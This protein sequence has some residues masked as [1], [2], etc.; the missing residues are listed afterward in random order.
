[1]YN[2]LPKPLTPEIF[3][4]MD[5][6]QILYLEITAPGGMGMAGGV[7]I[8]TMEKDN[9]NYYSTNY[10]QNK[11]LYEIVKNTVLM[12][13]DQYVHT[14]LLNPVI[15]FN[16]CYGGM[17][18]DTFMRSTAIIESV[19]EQLKFNIAKKQYFIKPSVEGIFNSISLWLKKRNNT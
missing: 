4:S 5:Y 12:Y 1:M 11:E 17:G 6:S 8:F 2:P 9:L 13:A 16:Y 10:F 14:I 19:N 3:Q 18:N 15:Y 7:L